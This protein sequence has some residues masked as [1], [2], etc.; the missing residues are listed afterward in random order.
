MKKAV[1]LLLSLAVSLTFACGKPTGP[2]IAKLPTPEPTAI[3]T[4]APTPTPAPTLAA[5][6]EPTQSAGLARLTEITEEHLTSRNGPEYEAKCRFE[7][8]GETYILMPDEHYGFLAKETEPYS[9]Y[10]VIYTGVAAEPVAGITDD[11]FFICSDDFTPNTRN[12]L[13]EIGRM[14]FVDG[15]TLEATDVGDALHDCVQEGNY[16]IGAKY[17]RDD[18][19]SESLEL[20]QVDTSD[21]S[22]TLLGQYGTGSYVNCF[23]YGI[24]PG[25][26]NVYFTVLA[27]LSSTDIGIYK[28]DPASGECIK[29][30]SHGLPYALDAD[31][32]LLYG[33]YS[34][35]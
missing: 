20:W 9:S 4:E 19:G 16:I 5:T 21:N 14:Y 24:S 6:A 1:I 10:E 13:P 27:D 25:D 22:R 31:G 26:G 32:I 17:F 28:L 23:F 29:V 33:D 35:N 34:G 8:G 2:H 7:F 11:G 15:H 3:V 12:C 30:A 18:H